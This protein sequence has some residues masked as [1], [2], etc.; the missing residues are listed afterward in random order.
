VLSF[1][2]EELMEEHEIPLRRHLEMVV[3]PGP[4]NGGRKAAHELDKQLKYICI[5]SLFR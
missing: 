5:S 1:H 3:A 2:A 4:P